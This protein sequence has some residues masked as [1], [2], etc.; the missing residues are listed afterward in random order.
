MPR[1]GRY[2]YACSRGH[3]TGVFL[4]EREARWDSLDCV[5]CGERAVRRKLDDGP[6]LPQIIDDVPE[7]WNVSLGRP[8][9]SRRHLKTLQ[10]QL[11]VQDYEPVQDRDNGITRADRIA[12]GRE[13]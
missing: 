9:R 7:H 3:E 1:C 10:N 5:T 6:D 11:G 13:P 12:L 8:V 2:T 4:S